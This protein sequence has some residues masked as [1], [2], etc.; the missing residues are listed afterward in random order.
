MG[1]SVTGDLSHR[2][3]KKR[4]ELWS[5]QEVQLVAPSRW[6]AKRASQSA[7]FRG[8]TV[9]VIPNGLDLNE[10]CPRDRIEARE[11][12]HLPQD[13]KIVLFGSCDP[14]RDRQ[15]GLSLLLEALRSM[16]GQN[17]EAVIFGTSRPKKILPMVFPVHYSGYINDPNELARL[18]SAA[19]VFVAPA[20]Q[21]NLPYTVME[22]MSCGTPVAAFD[23]G[24]M[25][26][27]VEHQKNGY[28]A[29][30]FDVSDLARGIRWILEENSHGAMLGS[31]ARQ[32]AEQEFSS[33]LC[34]ARYIS[35]YKD[36]LGR[37]S[38]GFRRNN[39]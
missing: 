35:L 10:F 13:K 25:P 30:P 39:V 17:M 1:S 20:A 37:C 15:K 29:R 28:L 18:Y 16:E 19:D 33:E 32:K 24:G 4:A 5:R 23:L 21:E 14:F 9:K 38:Q 2:L 11:Y 6:L 7:I 26:E 36:V 12:F 34:A 3:W 27:M 8:R 22:A 31:R